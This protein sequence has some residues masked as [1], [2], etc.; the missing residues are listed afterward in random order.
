MVSNYFRVGDLS[1]TA[2]EGFEVV[3]LGEIWEVCD[4]DLDR[5]ILREGLGL[6]LVTVLVEDYGA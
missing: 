4:V 2:E 1:V 3:F 5:L 6:D